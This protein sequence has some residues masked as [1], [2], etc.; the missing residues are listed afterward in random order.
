MN[1]LVRQKTK[2]MRLPG[3]PAFTLTE[4]LVTIVVLAMLAALLLPTLVAGKDKAR[5]VRCLSNL[6]QIHFSFCFRLLDRSDERLDGIE[7]VEWQVQEFGRADLGWICPNAPV[8]KEPLAFDNGTQVEGTVRSAW[9]DRHWWQDGGDQPL[10]G[11]NYRA[12]SYAVNDHLLMASRYR[13]WG[14]W[15]VYRMSRLDADVFRSGS[16]IRQPT[17]TPVIL[18]GSVAQV[19]AHASDSTPGNL[20]NPPAFGMWTVSLPRHGR[21]PKVPIASWASKQPFPGAVNVIF[22]DGHRELVKLDR[23]WGLHWHRD[24][25]PPEKRPGLPQGG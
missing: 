4:L 13:K 22:F 23:L 5:E 9:E 15:P 20:L 25:R 6:R 24:Y 19:L 1:A 10:F 12:G 7:G 14:Q 16:E 18:D 8:I 2:A 3:T 21:R 11:P 17:L